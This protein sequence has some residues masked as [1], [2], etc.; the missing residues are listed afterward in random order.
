MCSNEKEKSPADPQDS[1][2]CNYLNLPKSPHKNPENCQ[3]QRWG[4]KYATLMFL[5]YLFV[6]FLLNTYYIPGTEETL[7]TVVHIVICK[8]KKTD[9]KSTI[10]V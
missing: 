9:I 6:E 2:K 5:Y 7:T 10:T 3:H 1:G 4:S 8:R